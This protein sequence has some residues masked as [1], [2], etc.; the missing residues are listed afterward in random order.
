[1]GHLIWNT[2]TFYYL[3]NAKQKLMDIIFDITTLGTI[4]A[5]FKAF[6]FFFTIPEKSLKEIDEIVDKKIL[7]FGNLL[8]PDLVRNTLRW[9]ELDKFSKELE[10][11]YEGL[12]LIS[13]LDELKNAYIEFYIRQLEIVVHKDLEVDR[14]ADIVAKNNKFLMQII[15]YRMIIDPQIHLSKNVHKQTKILYMKVKGYWIND[16]GVKER[17]FSKSLGKYNL[18]TGGIKDKKAILEARVK[19]REIM[20]DEY[21]RI[22]GG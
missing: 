15:R 18:Y 4:T 8:N 19:I 16:Y 13:N 6:F 17:N 21:N 14:V 11:D 5:S 1:V 12:K 10:N 22:Y 2:K 20:L 7:Q 9:L 3:C